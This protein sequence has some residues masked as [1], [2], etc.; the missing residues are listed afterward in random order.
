MR[1]VSLAPSNTEILYA[2]GCEDMIVA[3]TRFCDYPEDAKKKPR[4]GGWLDVN[5]DLVAQYKPDVVMTSTF[6]QDKIVERYQKKGIALFHTDPKT[7][8]QVYESILAIGNLVGRVEKSQNIVDSMKKEFLRIGKNNLEK[9]IGEKTKID[10]GSREAKIYCEEWHK[11]PTVSGNWVPGVIERA[12]GISLCPE[13]KVSYPVALEEV[14]EFDPDL[15]IISICGMGAKASPEL[16]AK[17]EGWNG[18]RAVKEGKIFVIDDSLL[19]R[20]GPRLVD[21]AELIA[22]WIRQP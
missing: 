19:N 20:P 7:L 18:L 12:G 2:L 8:G 15:I 11:P 16:I 14:S 4:I 9:T 5:D 21:G 17:R 1:I 13:G 10:N 3:C 6:V 22:Q